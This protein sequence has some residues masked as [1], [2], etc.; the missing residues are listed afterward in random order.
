MKLRNLLVAVALVALGLAVWLAVG[1][2][3]ASRRAAEAERAWAAAFGSHDDLVRKHPKRA[4]N[5]T[6]KQLEPLAKGLGIGLAPVVAGT[7]PAAGAASEP[8]DARAVNDYVSSEIAKPEAAV[9]APPGLVA[10]FLDASGRDLDAIESLLASGP[11]PEWDFDL[12]LPAEERPIPSLRSQIRLQRMLMAR[13]LSAEREGRPEAAARALEASWNLNQSLRGRPETVSVLMAMAVSRLEMGVLRKVSA[14]DGEP[15]AGRVKG[16]DFRPDLL[17][18]LVLEARETPRAARRASA[19][20]HGW[21]ARARRVLD[22][23]GGP[24]ERLAMADYS[25][26]L[27]LRLSEL[28]G[29]PLA[30][31]LPTTPFPERGGLARA[32]SAIAI[33]NLENAFLRADRLVVDAELTAKVLEARRLRRE[34]GG[35]WPAAIPGVETSRYPG[36][37]WRYEALPATGMSLTF[38]RELASPYP[39]DVTPLP[40]RFTSP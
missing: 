16:T 27:R 28:R 26:A 18:A 37:S 11:P 19:R 40:L 31:S 17:D 32:M 25:D 38:S 1:N 2:A 35:R 8:E 33:P 30:D 13:A 7:R 14:V 3:R 4:T 15:W 10:R 22:L 12:T 6:A 36:A 20:R 24:R 23:V 9:G 5:E 34:G 21:R 39:K 29:A